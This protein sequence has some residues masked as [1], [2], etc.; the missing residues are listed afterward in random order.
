M[1][2]GPIPYSAEEMGWL[3]ANYRLVISDYHCAFVIAFGRSDVTAI[4]LNQLRKR[5]GWK[6]GRDGS[7]YIGRVRA[8]SKIEMDWLR[9]NHTMPIADYHWAFQEQFARPE[10]T[11]QKLHALRKR[12]GWKTGRTGHFTKGAPPLN[13]GRKCEPGKGGRHPGAQRTQ[14]KKGNEPHNTKCIGH[15]RV[16]KDG[17]IE[18]NVEE[19]N[20][21]TGYAHRYVH[22]HRWLWEQA[23]GPVPQG[24][25]LK[26][27]DSNKLNTDP[28]NWEPVHRGVLARLNGGRFRQTLPYDDASPD[29]KPLV[30][31]VA[32]LKHSVRETQQKRQR[33]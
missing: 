12:Q 18:I 26:C 4:H 13:K 15:E 25:V 20:P 23:N 14:F 33:S 3:E 17:Y 16:S 32:K 28:S 21:H 22:K 29:L 6:V 7:R 10:V 1:R 8:F 24:H 27:L 31:T 11:A 5:K 9:G 2:R 30:M 19:R